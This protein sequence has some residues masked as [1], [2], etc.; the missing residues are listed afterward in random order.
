MCSPEFPEATQDRIDYI[1]Y[2][3]KAIQ[4]NEVNMLDEHSVKWP[5]DHAAVMTQFILK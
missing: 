2:K 4:L 3:G 1:S 5:S